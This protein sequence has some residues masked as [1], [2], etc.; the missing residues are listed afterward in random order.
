MK[1]IAMT[2]K[3]MIRN[4]KYQETYLGDII[5]KNG[6]LRHTMEARIAKVYGALF[7]S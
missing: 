5:H 4:D 6:L 2:L 3:Y 7:N 1:A